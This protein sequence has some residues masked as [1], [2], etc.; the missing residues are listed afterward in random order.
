V[1]LVGF[2]DKDTSRCTV[3]C[4][5]NSPNYVLE[6][7]PLQAIGLYRAAHDRPRL[8]TVSSLSKCTSVGYVIGLHRN[9]VKY[10]T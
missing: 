5:S 1:H 8:A 9:T 7:S 4:M 10:I 2:R 3:L 6:L